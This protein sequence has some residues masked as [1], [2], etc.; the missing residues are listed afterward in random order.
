MYDTV[1]LSLETS[2]ISLQDLLNKL[3]W[4]N[5]P[6][7]GFHTGNLSVKGNIQNNSAGKLQIKFSDTFPQKLTVSGSLAKFHYGNNLEELT[8]AE[9]QKAIEQIS[10]R[11]S[12]D[13]R[14]AKV[15]RLDI[16]ANFIMD[17]PC[18]E[19]Q[20]LLNESPRMTRSTLSAKSN[21]LYFKNGRKTIILYDKVADCQ[22]LKEPIPEV[23]AGQHVLRYELRYMQNLPSQFKRQTVTAQTLYSELFYIE[24]LNKWKES[25]FAISRNE[26]YRM[27]EDIEIKK[28][29]ELLKHFAAIGIQQFGTGQV[30]DM[31]ETSRQSGKLSKM[32]AHRLKHAVKVITSTP[33]LVEPNDSIK[34]LDRKVTRAVACYR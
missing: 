31:L 10:E 21:S 17:R 16:G 1:H 3:D 25:Y 18:N 28:P 33:E 7:Q 14:Q 34:E 30:L 26:G 11:L 29:Q 32:Q 9:T 24:T 15:Y 6:S 20:S 5:E 2:G 23:F 22:R 19:Y 13:M 8:R 12:V 27:K 4:Y